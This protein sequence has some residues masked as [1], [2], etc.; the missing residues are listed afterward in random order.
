MKIKNLILVSLI[1]TIVT[2]GAV[3]ASGDI[4]D[5]ELTTCPAEE[6]IIEQTP[7]D[8]IISTDS[9]DENLAIT[10]NNIEI[11]D[12]IGFDDCGDIVTIHNWE[13]ENVTGNLIVSHNDKEYFN[14]DVTI[15]SNDCFTLYRSDAGDLPTGNI[16]LKVQFTPE[17]QTPIIAQKETIIKDFDIY[18]WQFLG[19]GEIDDDLMSFAQYDLKFKVRMNKNSTEKISYVFLGK[20]YDVDFTNG[21]G[22]FTIPSANLDLGNYSFEIKVGNKTRKIDFTVEELMLS[23]D[24][25]SLNQDYYISFLMPKSYTGTGYLY[26]YNDNKG[27][28]GDL[29]K[30]ENAVEGIVTILV[31][32]LEIGT[33]NFFFK[34]DSPDFKYNKTFE[35][36][37]LENNENIRINLSSTEIEYGGQIT[38]EGYGKEGLY[39]LLTDEWIV[40][41]KIYTNSFNEIISN[42]NPGK[43]RIVIYGEES[44]GQSNAFYNLFY[45]NVKEKPVNIND[46]INNNEYRKTPDKK[47]DSVKL[48][49]KKVKVKRSAKKLVL[50]ATLKINKKAVKGK[51]IIFKFNG[52]KYSALTNK[53]GVAKITIAKKVLKKLKVGKKVK[54]QASY[55]KVTKK[56]TVKVKR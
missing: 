38:V 40:S 5:D 8:E 17:G 41:A 12:E 26:E 49:L 56:V 10:E 2:I 44:S 42:L 18:C 7:T 46:N 39:V 32:K 31:P 43:H 13:N 51:R 47:A 55:G 45:V 1:L 3:C 37:V 27:T 34:F 21:E 20:T 6:D 23:Y 11:N 35:T 33:Y 24:F 53:K 9:E 22:Y 54:Y 50:T 28:V 52:K 4:S 36:I 16:L 48:T 29:I 25:I 14:A 15:P 30:Q 19:W